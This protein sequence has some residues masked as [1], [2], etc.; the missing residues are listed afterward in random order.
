MCGQTRHRSRRHERSEWASWPAGFAAIPAGSATAAPPADPHLRASDA[1]REEVVAALARHGASGR[2]D[3]D[4][5]AE[6]T[7]RAYAAKTVGELNGPLADLPRLGPDDDRGGEAAGSGPTEAGSRAPWIGAMPVGVFVAAVLAAA[8]L[9]APELLWA[10]FGLLLFSKGRS[11]GTWAGP[12]QWGSRRG[13]R[14][15]VGRV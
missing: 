7:E 6:R 3:P 5:L 2:L 1:Q 8:V 15:P 4:E 13:G 10:L 11:H 12:V 14:G 9:V